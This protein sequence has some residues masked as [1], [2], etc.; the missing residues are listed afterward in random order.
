MIDLTAF[1]STVISGGKAIDGFVVSVTLMVIILVSTFPF[2]SVAVTVT[3]V[4]FK[5]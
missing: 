4:L 3:S 5:G 1:A 2:S